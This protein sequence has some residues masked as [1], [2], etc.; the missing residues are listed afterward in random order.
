MTLVLKQPLSFKLVWKWWRRIQADLC[1][2]YQ[3]GDMDGRSRR[4][5]PAVD[6]DQKQAQAIFYFYADVDKQNE[7]LIKLSSK[8]DAN[9]II[10]VSKVIAERILNQRWIL[11]IFI[12]F[13]IKRK[14]Q[15][16]FN[17]TVIGWFLK[18]FFTAPTFSWR[19]CFTTQWARFKVHTV[20]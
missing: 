15:Q 19:L 20:N 11:H 2:L 16:V 17:H 7:M 6:H 3:S 9:P 14:L 1:G 4:R 18:M 10:K 13:E 8:N 5:V 12:I